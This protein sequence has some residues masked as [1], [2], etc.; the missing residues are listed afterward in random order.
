M[1][2]PKKQKILLIGKDGQV[3]WQLRRTLA[4][5]GDIAAYDHPHLDLADADQVRAIVKE[6]QPTLIV[7]AAAYT[8]VDKAES[9][10]DKAM[11]IN[12]TAPGMLAEE[13][14]KLG[15]GIVHYSTDYVFDGSKETPY[16]E[17][18]EPNPLNVY[19]KTKLTGDQAVQDS[20]APHLIFRTS[21]VYGIRGHNF[22]RTLLRLFSER[23]EISIV[24][25]QIG[26]PTWSRMIAE[27]TAQALGQAFSPSTDITLQDTSG[28]YNLTA[29]GET[30][31]YGF[32]Q[33]IADH[34][35]REHLT[36]K[37]SQ[38][39]PIPSEDYPLPAVRS[40]YGVLSH[41][42][43]NNTFGLTMPTWSEQL[44]LC[45]APLK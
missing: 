14:K 27:V 21:W 41:Q 33:A 16:T 1:N 35:S 45:I 9:E 15:A 2:T 17:D 26:A 31:W 38:L 28:L 40:K 12:G 5:L 4:P 42:K 37:I 24:D 6:V 20:G 22:L 32:A 34:A 11:A 8:D 25:D 39:K 18:D 44:E 10:S 29:A 23:E 43:L 19:G 30:S 7:N 36:P 13:A 3:G